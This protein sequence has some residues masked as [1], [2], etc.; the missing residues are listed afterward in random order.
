MIN[1]GTLST[2]SFDAD[3]GAAVSG[4]LG[5]GKAVLFT[6]DAGSFAGRAFLVADGNGLAG[7][8]AGEDYVIELIDP[9]TPIVAGAD[10]FI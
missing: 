2:A 6:A 8:Q 10:F 9:V 1:T 5:A 7:Y 4:A 3:L